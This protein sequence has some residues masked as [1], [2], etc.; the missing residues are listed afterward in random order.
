M[1]YGVLEFTELPS[2]QSVNEEESSSSKTEPTVPEKTLV[3]EN[4]LQ[5]AVEVCFFSF[6]TGGQYYSLSITPLCLYQT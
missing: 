1:F 3:D 5:L 4:L 6:Y 2:A